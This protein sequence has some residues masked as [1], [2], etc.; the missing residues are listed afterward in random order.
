MPIAAVEIFDRVVQIVVVDM[1]NI[2][3]FARLEL[4]GETLDM[5][6]LGGWG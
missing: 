5:S 4:R 1:S 3:P 6:L 2:V